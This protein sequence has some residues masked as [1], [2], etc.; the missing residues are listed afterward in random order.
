[1]R[2]VVPGGPA[3]GK[4]QV[5]DVVIRVGD[6]LVTE[7][8]PLEEEL[9]GAVGEEIAVHVERGG[10]PVE[11]KITVQDLHAITPDTYLEVGRGILHDLSYQQARNH[12]RKVAGVYLA[13]A[14]YMW[15]TAQVPVSSVIEEIDGEPIPDLDAAQRVLE[16]KAQGQRIR[17]RFSMV[18]DDRHVLDS[19]AGWLRSKGFR[20]DT[21][22]ECRT[23][24][25]HVDNSA[26]VQTVRRVENPRYYDLIKCF[27]EKTGVP[28]ILN[29]SYNLAG[30]P[31][32]ETPEDAVRSFTKSGL[33]NLVIGNYV[34]ERP[35]T[36]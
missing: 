13:V 9:D 27:G 16:S 29:T 17:V 1:M 5:G 28:V 21:A 33:R 34:A 32:V 36:A 18:D 31:I 12:N 30:D 11:A 23:A 6:R 19:M 7:F 24:I 3:D 20:V 15:S 26:R 4:L 14:G 35:T 22:G 25:T 8:V 2:Q 10:S